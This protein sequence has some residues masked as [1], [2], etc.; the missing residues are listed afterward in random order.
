MVLGDWLDKLLVAAIGAIFIWFGA[1]VEDLT[2][3]VANLCETMAAVTVELKTNKEQVDR[4][5]FDFDRH[6]EEDRKA[7]REQRVKP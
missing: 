7:F 6:Q 4:L 2:K 3:K 1:K 5:R